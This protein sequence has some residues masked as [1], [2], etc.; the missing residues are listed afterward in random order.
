MCIVTHLELLHSEDLWVD[1]RELELLYNS[2]L[3]I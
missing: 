2:V 1:G 3:N